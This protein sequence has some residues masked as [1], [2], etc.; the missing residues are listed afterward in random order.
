M[1]FTPF[2]KLL[3]TIL[4]LH[5]STTTYATH[6]TLDNTYNELKNEL[7]LLIECYIGKT[8]TNNLEIESINIIPLKNN[9]LIKFFKMNFEVFFKEID[10]YITTP[11]LRSIVDNIEVIGH[12]LSYLLRMK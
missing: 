12:R 11:G 6:V 10:P 9:D 1:K 2:L 5:W 3:N 8:L 7:D 4:V